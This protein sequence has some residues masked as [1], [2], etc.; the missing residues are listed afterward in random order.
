MYAAWHTTLEVARALHARV[1]VFQ[2]PPS[3]TPTEQHRRDL[4]QFFSHIARDDPHVVL[5]W[6]PRGAW[7]DELVSRLCRD[8]GL[9]HC[10]D[11]F[12]RAPLPGEP[13]YF[14]LHGIGGYRYLYTEGDLLRLLDMCR[15]KQEVYCLFN[16]VQMWDSARRFQ[17]LVSAAL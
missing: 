4:V 3:F 12:R 7:D 16:N 6:E 17:A 13:A 8:L 10:V 9:I 1:I 5:A 14:R 11:P 2:C 15:A